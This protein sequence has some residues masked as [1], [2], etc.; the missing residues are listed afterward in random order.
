MRTETTHFELQ[1]ADGPTRTVLAR[2]SGIG[3]WPAGRG[4][5]GYCMGGNLA[6][7]CAGL[8][9]EQLAAAASFHG[10][11]LAH[12]GADSPHQLATKMKAELYVAGAVED[13]SFPDPMKARLEA[14]LSEAHVTHLIE[15]YPARHG[16]AV[17][18]SPVFDAAAAER[19]WAAL[20]ALFTRR[21]KRPA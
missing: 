19:H 7:R 11:N 14:A 9:P 4:V 2:P 6:L 18:D 20:E 15:T 12:D 1:T 16:F 3:T 21:L 8:F 5:T 13:P 10:G 17:P